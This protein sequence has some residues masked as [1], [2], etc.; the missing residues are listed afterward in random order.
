M[1][2]NETQGPGN[3]PNQPAQPNQPN[4]KPNGKRRFNIMWIYAI[5]AIV[6]IGLNFLG[7]DA[8]TPQ[9]EIDQGK[10]IEMLKK[11]EI[12]KIDL[13]N[14]EDAEVYL[15][16]K[17]LSV[18]FPEVIPNSDGFTA[19]PN[20]TYKI[21]SLDR[22]EEMVENAQQEVS[23]PVYITNVRRNNW[24]SDI[25]KIPQYKNKLLYGY[26]ALN[27][28][29]IRRIELF[30]DDFPVIYD[31]VDCSTPASMTH[32][33]IVVQLSGVTITG[34]HNNIFDVLQMR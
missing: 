32:A 21:G 13:V 34:G 2:N 26:A 1:N 6:L 25:K 7:R 10:L 20:Y 19:T 23:N 9:E 12:G 33:G 5:L 28:G 15:N 18:Y 16:Q 8:V 14:R 31:V 30:V 17:G 22:F 11:G 29:K 4:Q 24:M 3:N 27:V